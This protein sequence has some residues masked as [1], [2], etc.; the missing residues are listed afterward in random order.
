MS[1]KIVLLSSPLPK[2]GKDTVGEYLVDKYSFKRFAFADEVKKFLIQLGWN[3]KKDEKGRE[4]LIQ[5]AELCKKIDP[6]IWVKKVMA[7]I[8]EEPVKNIVITDLRF[9]IE[10]ESIKKFAKERGYEIIHLGIERGSYDIESI[11]TDVS[12]I[13]YFSFQNMKVVENNLSLQDLYS[14]IDELIKD[15]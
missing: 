14:K 1:K 11:K 4:L 7:K 15:K 5:F 10:D 3:G 8:E 6:A 12:Q 9:S 2:M 13:A